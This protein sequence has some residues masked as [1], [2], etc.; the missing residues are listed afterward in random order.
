[1]NN[2]ELSSVH[3]ANTTDVDTIVSNAAPLCRP[4]HFCRSHPQ[5]GTDREEVFG[6]MLVISGFVD[7]SGEVRRGKHNHHLV[8]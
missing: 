1:M 8:Y 3:V 2:E 4:Y 6:P 7:H 5:R